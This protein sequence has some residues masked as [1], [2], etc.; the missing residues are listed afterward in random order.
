MGLSAGECFAKGLALL[1]KAG[2]ANPQ[3]DAEILAR[4]ACGMERYELKAYPERQLTPD[5]EQTAEQYFNRRCKFEPVAYILGE[6]EFYSLNFF[7]NQ[8]VLIPRPETELLV[9]LAVYYTPQNSSL[10]DI[11]TGSGCVAIAVKHSRRDI[12]VTAS[13]ISSAAIN[14]AQKN[15][16]ALLGDATITFLQGDMFAPVSRNRFNCITC[17]PPYVAE[18]DKD[19]I[20][21]DLLY[22]PAQAL[23]ADE[24]GTAMI[25]RAINECT[26]YLTNDGVLLLEI[27]DTMADFVK[28][29]GEAVGFH[30]SVMNDYGGLPRAAV[31]KKQP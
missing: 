6:K 14:I 2:V 9:D 28:Q 29:T 25:R 10:L 3:L 21:A 22:E 18:E 26:P 7:V 8:N 16:K 23:F 17:N 15:A 19:E 30:V 4:K 31:L 12:A 27:G 1:S 24:G 5:M 20:A 11:C 13:D